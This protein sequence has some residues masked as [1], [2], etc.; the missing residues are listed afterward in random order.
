MISIL[1][2]PL[3]VVE[4]PVADDG[5]ACI[6]DVKDE[7]EDGEPDEVGVVLFSALL[8]EAHSDD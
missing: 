3:G 8:G 1:G 7:E 5:E 6:V 2:S 4:R